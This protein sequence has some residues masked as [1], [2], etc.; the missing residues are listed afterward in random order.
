MARGF[1]DGQIVDYPYLWRW[2]ALEGRANAE[3]DRPVCLAL[4]LKSDS[5]THL[6]ILPISGSPPHN[7]RQALEIP[8]LELRRAGLSTFRRGWLSVDEYNYDV[9]ERSYYFDGGQRP[10]G[11][12]SA[13]FLKEILKAIRPMLVARVGRI[14]RTV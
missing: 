4:M 11:A 10:R 1:E 5:I 6:I 8:Q 14:D 7:D 2:Q 3:K 12:F 9:V 13:K